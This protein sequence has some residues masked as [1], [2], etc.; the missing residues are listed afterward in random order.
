MKLSII[1]INFNDAKGLEKTLE[2]ITP[3]KINGVELVIIDGGST[4]TSLDV[5]LHHKEAIDYY[6]S[7]SDKGIYNAMN[8]GIKQANG[9]YLLFINSGDVMK[10][11]ID[12]E[13]TITHLAS[14]EDII[15]FDLEFI[16][17]NSDFHLVKR[18]TNELDFKYFCQDSLPHPASFIRKELF[19]KYGYYREDLKI[20]SDWAFYIDTIIKH[21]C[22]FRRVEECFSTFFLDGISSN[23]ENITT[24]R[25]EQAKHIEE[26]YAIYYSLYKDWWDRGNELYRIKTAKSIKY[27]KKIGFLKWLKK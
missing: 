15:Y 20:V 24:T 1:T 9:Q 5:I 19:E 4:D 10:T 16:D 26:N 8:K 14:G 11:D 7:E 18:Y 23:P 13:K 27:L 17:P 12:F 21:G 3:Y 6:V 25:A 2:S 22:S